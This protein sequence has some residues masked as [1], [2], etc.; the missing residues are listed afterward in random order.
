MKPEIAILM[1][2]HGAPEYVELSIRSL[3]QNTSEVDYTLVVV[4]NASKEATRNLVKQLQSEGLIQTLHLSSY[5]SMFAEGN[6]IAARLAPESTTHFLLLN[7]DVEIR[8]RDWLAR[9]LAIH[10]RGASAYGAVMHSPVRADGYCLLIDADLY[11]SYPLDEQHQWWWSVTKQQATLLRNGFSVQ[12][13]S[14]HDEYLYH[15]GGKS[16]DSFKMAAGSDVTI[17]QAQYWFEGRKVHILD[18]GFSN[19][20]RRRFKSMS[21]MLPTSKG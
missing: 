18:D 7:S 8:S 6:N 15:F 21:R 5:N 4:D 17:E 13:Y 3:T 16:G 9:L 11:R 19:R 12:A 1:L 10:K 14:E 20:W 2:T